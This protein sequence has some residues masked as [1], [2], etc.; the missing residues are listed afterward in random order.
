MVLEVK[1][2]PANIGDLG[3]MGLIF[4]LGRFPGVRNGILSSILTWRSPRTEE[5][6]GLQ[7][8]GLQIVGHD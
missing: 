5:P 8:T 2:M 3:D 6:G 7:H 1:N 4:E